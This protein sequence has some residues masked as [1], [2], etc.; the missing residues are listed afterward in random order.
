M[1]NNLLLSIAGLGLAIGSLASILPL[2]TL[3][4]FGIG[5]GIMV[6]AIFREFNN[7]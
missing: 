7:K 3:I 1:K 2:H 4:L 5:L 6:G